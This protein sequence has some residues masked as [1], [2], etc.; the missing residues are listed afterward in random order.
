MDC[1]ACRDRLFDVLDAPDAGA[2]GGEAA[3]HLER[4]ADCREWWRDVRGAA[5]CLRE[6]RPALLEAPPL[7]A[8][9]AR[10]RKAEA[11]GAGARRRAG[12]RAAAGRAMDILGV[13]LAA[14]IIVVAGIGVRALLPGWEI[15]LR[16]LSQPSGSLFAEAWT[17]ALILV[18]FGM[19]AGA[20][21]APLIIRGRVHGP[22]RQEKW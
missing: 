8:V 21:S 16:A 19:F 10:I 15:P 11:A 1:E 12:T 14:A 22:G 7:S 20:C 13:L 3:A 17:A 2:P 5:R 6:T 18:L 9:W 4:C